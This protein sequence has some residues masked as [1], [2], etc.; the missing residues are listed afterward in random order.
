MTTNTTEEAMELL[1][2]YR[3]QYI[4]AARSVADQLIKRNGTTDT[5]QVRI[6]MADNGALLNDVKDHWLGAV[7]RGPRYQ[8]TG[9]W[10]ESYVGPFTHAPR[11]VK[12]WRH[13]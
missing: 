7:F 13:R 8:W 9:E 12:V 4:D 3:G 2:Q 10:T 5:K 11:P 1:R 6:A